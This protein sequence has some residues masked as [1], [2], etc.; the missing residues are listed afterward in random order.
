MKQHR[1]IFA[2]LAF[3]LLASFTKVQSQDEGFLYGKVTTIEGKSYEGALR[4]G[5]EE[6]YWTDL[7]NASKERNENLNYLS[8]EERADLEERYHRHNNDFGDRVGEW[9]NVRWN[10]DSGDDRHQHQFVCQF[11]EIKTIKPTGRERARLVLK[12]GQSFDVDGDG[13]NDIGTK[14]KVMDAEIGEVELSWSR[15]ETIEFMKAPSKI[16]NKFGEPLYGTVETYGGTFTGFIQWD[17]DERVSTDKLDGDTDDGDVSIEF[18]KLKSIEREGFRSQVVLA[19][20]RSMQL[21]GSNDV[22]SENRGIVVTNNKFGRVD[23]PWKEFKKVT[24]ES[25]KEKPMAY[26]DFKAQKELNAVVKTTNGETISGRII[27]D[28]D[29]SYDYE[30]LQGMNEDIEYIIAFKNISKI[31]PKNYDNSTIVL[32]NG[33]QIMLSEGQDVS[34]KNTGILVFKEK[35]QP[36]Y[37]PWEKVREIIFN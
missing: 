17:H 35:D 2:M 28:L 10:H 12:G 19:S 33:E 29:E 11:G 25:P 18:G 5:K 13:Y 31:M 27:Y 8:R 9:F 22:N 36:T 7:F 15:I 30:V 26:D 23:I 1:T 6:A 32:K 4:W 34:D 3:I 20:G 24:F 14:V 37:I 16:T 21:S